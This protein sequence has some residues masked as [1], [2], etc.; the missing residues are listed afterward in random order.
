[1]GTELRI[2]LEGAAGATSA[3]AEAALVEIERF[4]DLLSTWDDRTLL[5]RANRAEQGAPVALTPELYRLLE[6]ANRWAERTGGAFEPAVGALIDA[7]DLRGAGRRPEDAELQRALAATGRT[8][9][10]L[11][12]ESGTLTRLAAAWIDTGGF[13][14]GAALRSAMDRLRAHEVGHALLDL[15]GQLVVWSPDGKAH[16]VAVAHPDRRDE[17]VAWL[18]LRDVSIATSGNAE[19]GLTVEGGRV[20][21]ILDPRTGLPAH[22]FGSVTVVGSDPLVADIL[23]TA[24]F[25]MGPDAGMA[26]A[27]DLDDVGVLFLVRDGTTLRA[28]H[29]PAMGRWLL[30]PAPA[31]LIPEP[32]LQRRI[33]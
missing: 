33:P 30:E 21:H 29:N 10:V 18:E 3:A 8:T 7:W 28:L 2:A 20:G 26:W 15:G 6:E 31:G 23:S 1:M 19:R 12:P 11:D 22:D 32:T 27:A 5:S 13:G 9:L 17:A 24:L 4:E 16:R 14:K 25:V